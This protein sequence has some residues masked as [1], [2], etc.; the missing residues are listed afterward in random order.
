MAHPHHRPA[1]ALQLK[2]PVLAVADLSAELYYHAQ[3]ELMPRLGRA[4]QQLSAH[5]PGLRLWH[6][7]GSAPWI[8][9]A[10]SHLGIPAERLLC[11]HR[12]PHLQASLL[13]VPSYSS[14]FGRP[15]VCSL[16]WLRGFWGAITERLP[17][18]DTSGLGVFLSRSPAQRR[19]LLQH[20]RWL[21]ATRKLGL[22]QPSL[23]CSVAQQLRA[24][25]RTERVVMAHGGAMANLL[26]M[27]PKSEVIELMNPGYQP[28]YS[29]SLLVSANQ[30]HRRCLGA[31]TPQILQDLL[32]A[33]PLE[34]PLDLEP[35]ALTGL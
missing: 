26:L 33:G 2:E 1:A 8:S 11:A 32:Y 18:P 5:Y 28:P 25:Q 12:H 6:N 7:G 14:S 21:L 20:Q 29:T 13:L 30:R 16:R 23:G 22:Y 15:G 31:V 9:E 35:S 19:P 4:W 34:W 24:L 3:L 27:R 17:K 10:L